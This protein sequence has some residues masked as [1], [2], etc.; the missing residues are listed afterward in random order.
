MLLLSIQP[1]HCK[2]LLASKFLVRTCKSKSTFTVKRGE[3]WEECV[4][5]EGVEY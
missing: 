5:G 3:I 2:M 1:F 4:C